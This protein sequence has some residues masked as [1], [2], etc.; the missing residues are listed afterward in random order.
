MNHFVTKL[1]PLAIAG[2]I[3]FILWITYNGIN[4]QFAGTLPEKISYVSL[5]ILLL[6]NIVLLLQVK[7]KSK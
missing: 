3:L 2:N 6:L 4:E 1:S 7:H 5:M